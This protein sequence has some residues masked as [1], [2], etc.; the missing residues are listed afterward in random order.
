MSELSLGLNEELLQD[1]TKYLELLAKLRP[2]KVR[3]LG[4]ASLKDEPGNY[5]INNCDPA[6]F[7]PFNKLKVNKFNFSLKS[8][9]F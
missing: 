1:T 5:L 9:N 6:L 7:M 2:E 8:S 4:L 3:L